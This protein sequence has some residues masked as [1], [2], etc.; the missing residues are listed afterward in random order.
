MTQTNKKLKTNQMMIIE[1]SKFGTIEIGHKTEMGN[2]S[3][4]IDMGNKVRKENGLTPLTINHILNK[5]EFW[6]FVIARNTLLY[7]DS[8]S[9]KLRELENSH[10]NVFLPYQ[11]SEQLSIKSNFSILENYKDL[12]GQIQYSELMKKFPYLIK[13]RRGRYGGTWAELYILLKIASM[14]D[15]DLEVA[16]YDVFIKSQILQHR[17]NGGDSFKKLNIAIDKYIPSESGNSRGRFIHI[18]TMLRK[19]LEI[20]KTKGYNEKEHNSIIQQK[21]DEIEKFLIGA[22]QTKLVTSYEKLKNIIEDFEIDE[23]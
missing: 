22:L 3:Q 11:I 17:D 13:S 20:T 2:V 12:M 5:S 9:L 19:K 6:E 23:S 8:N 16:I 21:R 10:K 7:K 15:K 18:A 1:I 4:V 14:L